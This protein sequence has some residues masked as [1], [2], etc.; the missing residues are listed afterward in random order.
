MNPK[1]FIDK[2]VTSFGEYAPLPLAV[3]YSESPLGERKYVTGCMFKQF[4]RAYNGE[5]VTLDTAN[6]T[7]G[8]GTLYAGLGPI[9][10]GVYDFVSRVEKYKDSQE[11]AKV[12]IAGIDPHMSDSPYLNLVRIDKLETFDDMEGLIFLVT[13]DIL[14]GLFTWANYDSKDLNAVQCPWGSGCSTT[15]T[16]LVN[17]NRRNGKHCYIGM[18]DVSARPFFK[19]DI[20]SFSIPRSRFMEMCGTLSQCCVSGAPAWLKVKKRI[21]SK[22]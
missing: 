4:H 15:I 8:G 12:S 17:E 14:S 7:C 18:F 21:N 16:S 2:Y 3:I 10:M 13:P 6:F 22:R 19:S 11:T 1:E 9:P 20:L 5:P